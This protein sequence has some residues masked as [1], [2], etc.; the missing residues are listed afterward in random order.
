MKNIYSIFEQESDQD[1][2][3]VVDP[4]LHYQNLLR[5]GDNHSV[6]RVM[7]NGVFFVLKFGGKDTLER[8]LYALER[9]KGLS[10]I[11]P[12]VETYTFE[13][14][15]IALLKPYINGIP[16]PI[17]L[18]GQTLQEKLQGIVHQVHTRGVADLLLNGEHIIQ[19]RGELYLFDFDEAC[20]DNDEEFEQAKRIDLRDIERIC[21]RL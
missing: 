1:F 9:L 10:N 14:G 16:I 4:N 6:Y 11:V 5:C 13:D 8:E 15:F 20:Y 21:G 19:R 17:P 2:I 12:V 7:K 18:K 3:Q